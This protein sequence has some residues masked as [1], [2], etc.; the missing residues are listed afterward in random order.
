[1]LGFASNRFE[2]W[3]GR[4]DKTGPINRFSRLYPVH[5]VFS[6][7]PPVLQS[8]GSTCL[9]GPILGLVHGPTGRTGRFGFNNIGLNLEYYAN[10]SICYSYFF[11][12]TVGAVCGNSVKLTE[13]AGKKCA[14]VKL[15][16][17][18]K[19]ATEV[20][21][22]KRGT[23]INPFENENK[24]IATKIR[25]RESVMQGEGISTP[26]IRCIQREP[27]ISLALN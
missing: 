13:A 17:N 7:F 18:S 9:S 12:S 20:L 4:S 3:T 23:S 21:F 2:R 26:R 25:V 10:P 6:V 16:L 22:L 8:S 1:M 5:S 24:V 11:A 19:V 27:L 14:G 15:S